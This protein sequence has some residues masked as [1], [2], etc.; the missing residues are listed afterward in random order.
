MR[1]TPEADKDKTTYVLGGVGG[2]ALGADDSGIPLGGRIGLAGAGIVIGGILAN[3]RNDEY[4]KA[5]EAEEIGNPS[6]PS[7]DPTSGMVLGVRM[8]SKV[9][10]G[11]SFTAVMLRASLRF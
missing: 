8:N 3:S 6:G 7:P 9:V 5:K 11:V 4:Q 2:I 10:V 1:V